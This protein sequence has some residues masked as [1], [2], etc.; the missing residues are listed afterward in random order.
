M[1]I[2][3]FNNERVGR[4]T[5]CRKGEVGEREGEARGKKEM[6]GERREQREGEL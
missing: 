1:L 6:R 5:A 4:K 3:I 2:T